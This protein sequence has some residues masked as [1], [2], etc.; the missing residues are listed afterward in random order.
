MSVYVLYM[1]LQ[2][3]DK[4]TLGMVLKLIYGG[5]ADSDTRSQALLVITKVTSCSLVLC[6]HAHSLH[7]C[8]V[9]FLLRHVRW[10]AILWQVPLQSFELF[11][12]LLGT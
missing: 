2:K 11:G 7:S 9:C 4:N 10:L 6:V 3:K 12:A 1:Y 8:T 5:K